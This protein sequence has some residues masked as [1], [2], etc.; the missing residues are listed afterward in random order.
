MRKIDL[1]NYEAGGRTFE[2]RPSLVA[3]LFNE[4]KL[5]GREMIRRDALATRIET[6]SDDSILLEDIDWAKFVSGLQATD[7]KPLGRNVVEF[8]KRLL[9]APVVAVQEKA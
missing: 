3:I 9:D 4:E 6:C 5:D 2:V 1:T 7:L 8:V